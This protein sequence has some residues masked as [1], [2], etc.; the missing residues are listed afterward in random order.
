MPE[1][2]VTLTRRIAAPPEVVFGVITDPRQHV[3]IDGSGM[4]VATDAAP[5]R[6]VGDTFDMDMDR[7]SLGDLP[8]GKYKVR[9]TVTAIEPDAKLE[10]NV[11]GVDLPPFGHVYGYELRPVGP[12]ATDVTL[13]CDWTE[14]PASSIRDRFPIV[15]VHMLE[16]SLDN[17]ERIATTGGR[18]D[19]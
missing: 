14:V 16:Q 1:T 15:P 7:E 12:E 4:L 6:A 18:L 2:R 11:G 17:L 3:E 19:S 13:Y 8:M 10:W 5:L 9:N